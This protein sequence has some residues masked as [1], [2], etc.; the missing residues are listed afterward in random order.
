MEK[1]FTFNALPQTLEELKAMPEADLTDPCAAV[2]LTVAALCRYGTDK[3]ACVEMLDFLR[4]PRPLSPYDVQFLR[5][6]LG[7]KEYKPFSFFAG[8]VPANDY[9]PDVPYVI[10]VCENPVMPDENYKQFLVRSG[11][12]DNPRQVTVRRKGD[13]QWLLW[14]EMLLSD[15][16]TPKSQDPWA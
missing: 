16:R 3:D 8:A 13:G 12:A 9:A 1:T 11:G 10:T 5:D 15:I 7:G 6:R 14:E 4:G 2:A